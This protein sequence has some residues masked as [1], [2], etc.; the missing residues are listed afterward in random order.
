[1]LW[2][3]LAV[4]QAAQSPMSVTPANPTVVVGQTQQFT[5]S[6]AMTAGAVSA[7]GEYTCVGLSDGTARCTGRNQFGQLGDG[8]WTDSP[9]LVAVSGITT[10]TRVTAGD[11]FACALLANGTAKCWGLG[12]S[13]Q[14][15]DGTFGTFALTPVAVNG[16]TGAVGLAAGYGHTC[17]LLSDATMRCW[18]ENREGQLGNGTTAT[19]GIP[20][21]VT[22][23]GISGVTAFTTG[24]YHT[25]A[26][27]ANGALQCWGRNGNAQLGN[28]TYTNASTPVPVTGLT[29][30]T[31]V[32]GGGAHTCAVLTDGTVRCWGENDFGQL[33]DGTTTPATTPVQVVGLSG[34]VDISAGW[35]HTCARLGSGTIQCWGQNQF[36]QLGN[37]TT[38][39]QTTPVPVSGITGAVGVTAGW[40]HHSC[41]LLGGGT[42]RCWGAND[43]GQF[44]IGTT[45]GSSTPV[46]MFP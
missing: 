10:A 17:A 28:G 42:V 43:W 3:G 29:S 25:C 12:E 34:V 37:G 39:T 16:L 15:G 2:L 8:S 44:G 41:A 40:W 30:A 22:V 45:T 4:R 5:A 46:T 11:E 35:R 14:R 18:G 26:V 20:Q 23:S 38:T 1:V 9:V 6:G 36:G 19:P 24:A 21:P 13:G 27:L 33:G 31:A 32:S 7:G